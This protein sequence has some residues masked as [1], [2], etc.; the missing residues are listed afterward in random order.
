MCYPKP[1]PRC[2]KHAKDRLKT[3]KRLALQ[4]PTPERLEAVEVAQREYWL[5]PAGQNRL[6]AEGHAELADAYEQEHDRM[7]AEYHRVKDVL[8]AEKFPDLDR[9]A[10]QAAADAHYEQ[11]QQGKT[12][13][14]A[15]G[16]ERTFIPSETPYENTPERR[17]VNMLRHAYTDYDAQ[18]STTARYAAA[19]RMIAERYP[20][21]AQECDEQTRVRIEKDA[22]LD[23]NPA[24]KWVKVMLA[25]QTWVTRLAGIGSSRSGMPYAILRAGGTRSLAAVA[26]PSAV[27][28]HAAEAEAAQRIRPS[29]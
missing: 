18:N 7:L 12:I 21:L 11:R 10:L 25:G 20:W 8:L 3:A 28:I 14:C 16:M 26:V 15:D 2:S 9:E 17:C 23:G 29:A 1:G 13:E 6:R 24:G 27:E 4:N 5:T 22:Y 19:N